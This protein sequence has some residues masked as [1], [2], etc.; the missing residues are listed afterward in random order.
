[1]SNH[2][3]GDLQTVSALALKAGT[4]MDMQGLGYLNTLKNL[5]TRE[6]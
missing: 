4:D 1:M 6:R 2:G 5:L 3:L